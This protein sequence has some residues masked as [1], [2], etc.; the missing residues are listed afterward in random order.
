M[1]ITTNSSISV[2]PERRQTDT[3]FISFSLRMGMLRGKGRR[4]SGPRPGTVA[5]HCCRPL[6]WPSGASRRGWRSGAARRCA[7]SGRRPRDS[8]WA[9]VGTTSPSRHIRPRA[10]VAAGVAGESEVALLV[11]LGGGVQFAA[12]AEGVERDRRPNRRFALEEHLTANR[13]DGLGGAFLAQPMTNEARTR[14]SRGR[15]RRRTTLRRQ[16]MKTLPG[17]CLSPASPVDGTKG[18][19][20][21]SRGRVGVECLRVVASLREAS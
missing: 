12:A 2:K 9:R 14:N 10:T 15:S 17:A 11:G 20:R 16:G 4:L 8:A 7:C 18:S 21:A 5:S 19:R 6:R 1:A 13:M 3:R